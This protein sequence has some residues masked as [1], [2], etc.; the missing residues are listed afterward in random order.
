M[1]RKVRP[2]GAVRPR[3]TGRRVRTAVL[4]TALVSGLALSV[5]ALAAD[6][7][8]ATDAEIQAALQRDLGLTAQQVKEQSALQ[9]QAIKRDRELQASLGSAYAGSRFDARTGKLI[10]MVSDAT[11]LDKVRS[12]GAEAKLVKHSKA[13]LEGIRATFDAAIGKA[14]GR[15]SAARASAP[16]VD[17]MLSWYVD[18]ATN[19]VRVTVKKGRAKVVATALARYGDAV[20]IAQTDAVPTAT[21]N[22][23][24]GGDLINF[25]SCSAGFNLRNPSTGQG[26]LLTAG[27]CVSTGSTLFGQGNVPFGRVLESWSSGR[28]DAIARND[29]PATG[30]RAAGSTSTPPTAAS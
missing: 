1:N 9:A 13:R 8:S 6:R 24:D 26:Y 19:T 23:M 3:R 28:D 22:F 30:S 14:T 29:N 27:H 12:F 25:G 18:T 11:Q 20:T 7:E 15:A 2:V 21:A 17:G 10:T 16:V 5:P 4:T